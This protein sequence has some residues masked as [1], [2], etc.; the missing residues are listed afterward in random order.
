M[1]PSC[2]FLVAGRLTPRALETVLVS[3]DR[4]DLRSLSPSLQYYVPVCDNVP[5]V[6]SLIGARALRQ[7]QRTRA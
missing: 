5:K 1:I 6:F 2:T 7:K 4:E 3:F